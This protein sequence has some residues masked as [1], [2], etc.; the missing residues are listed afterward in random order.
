MSNFDLS[1]TT[2]SHLDPHLSLQL[3]QF[4]KKNNLYKEEELTKA[5]NQL[6]SHTKLNNEKSEEELKQLS[7]ELNPLIKFFQDKTTVTEL[8]KKKILNVS[9]LYQDYKVIFFLNID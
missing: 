7:S 6:L 2:I 4:L 5:S 8:K 1:S 3:I 9:T